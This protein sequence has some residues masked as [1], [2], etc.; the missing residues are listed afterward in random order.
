MGTAVGT[1]VFVQHGWRAASGVSMAWYGFQLAVLLTRG[2]HVQRYSWVGWEGGWQARKSVFDA[3]RTQLVGQAE[4]NNGQM[5]I[6]E[7]EGAERNVPATSGLVE[8]NGAGQKK[9]LEQKDP[10]QQV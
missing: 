10:S 5:S 2:P 8:A 6:G 7:K 9:G 1:Q 4:P 3:Q